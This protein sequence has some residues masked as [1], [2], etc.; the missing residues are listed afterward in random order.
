MILPAIASNLDSVHNVIWVMEKGS[1]SKLA[2]SVEESLSFFL[3][4]SKNFAVLILYNDCMQV[5]DESQNL[6]KYIIIISTFFDIDM[7]LQFLRQFQSHAIFFTK[8]L[9]AEN[10]IGSFG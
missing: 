8:S 3:T 6:E 2:A 1:S 10:L 9:Q 5:E 7:W 4:F